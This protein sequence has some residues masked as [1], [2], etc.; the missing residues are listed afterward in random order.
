MASGNSPLSRPLR[1]GSVPYLVARPLNLGLEH[2]A[3]IELSFD[4]PAK[5]SPALRAGEL[6]VALVSSIELFRHPGSSYLPGLGVVG[7][8]YVGSV[9]L[10][11]RQTLATIRSVALDPASRTAQALMQ[12][13]AHEDPDLP[14]SIAFHEVPLG[15]DPR[16]TT[17]DGLAGPADAFLRIGDVALREHLDEGLPHYNPSEAWARLTGLPFVFAA[18]IARPGIDLEPHRPAFEAAAERGLAAAKQLAHETAAL[19][20]LDPAAVE[21]YL[22]QECS[23]R[24]EPARQAAALEA[25]EQR[26]RQVGLV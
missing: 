5:L 1:V 19:W 13:L 22:T 12:V 16:T 10:F 15:V 8:G 21:H 25:F 23:F 24:I 26:A 7:E 4:V 6:D 2:E 3:G 11:L 17:P 18:W 9:Q 14:S 20:R